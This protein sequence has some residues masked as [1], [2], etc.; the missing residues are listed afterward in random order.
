MSN[1]DHRLTSQPSEES[2][3]RNL[4]L[5]TESAQE[6]VETSCDFQVTGIS[7]LS[8]STKVMDLKGSK[9]VWGCNTGS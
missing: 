5:S 4:N 6:R 9:K 1:R 8:S 7:T 2:Q 3:G